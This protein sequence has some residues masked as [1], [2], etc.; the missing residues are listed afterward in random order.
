MALS[1]DVAIVQ[2]KTPTRFR[3]G[4]RRLGIFNALNRQLDV[5]QIIKTLLD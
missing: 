2:A 5:I 4:Q 1:I 3:A